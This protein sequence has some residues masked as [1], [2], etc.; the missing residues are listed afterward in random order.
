MNQFFYLASSLIWKRLIYGSRL[1]A[2]QVFNGQPQELVRLI[3]EPVQSHQR[4]FSFASN[5]SQVFDPSGS[6]AANALSLPREVH[7]VIFAQL[8]TVEDVMT[9]GLSN[10]YFR[11]LALPALHDVWASRPGIWAGKNIVVAGEYT[12]PRDYPRELFLEDK[13]PYLNN[14]IVTEMYG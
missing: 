2:L 5:T 8:E 6:S 11:T 14:N 12:E 4:W 9:S 7:L 3:A 1:G 10:V 13:Q